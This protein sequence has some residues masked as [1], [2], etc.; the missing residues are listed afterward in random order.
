MALSNTDDRSWN[1]A[2]AGR[3]TEAA[4]PMTGE[5]GLET[6]GLQPASA[7]RLFLCAGPVNP[8]ALDPTALDPIAHEALSF[9]AARVDCARRT[10]FI[11]LNANL[12]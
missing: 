12:Q 9:R 10:V 4:G 6:T 8:I 7:N 3:V 5:E 11:A 2:T 1:D